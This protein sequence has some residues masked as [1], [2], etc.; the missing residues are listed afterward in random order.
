M[1]TSWEL[2]SQWEVSFSELTS[3]KIENRMKGKEKWSFFCYCSTGKQRSKR[4]LPLLYFSSFFFFLCVLFFLLFFLG[5]NSSF[6][7]LLSLFFFPLAIKNPKKHISQCIHFRYAVI[8]RMG[9]LKLL[10]IVNFSLTF[11]SSESN[12]WNSECSLF[13]LIS[14]K[15]TGRKRKTGERREG[16]KKRS[17]RWKQQ[18]LSNESSVASCM[19]C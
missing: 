9:S 6:P 1:L 2:R 8:W 4:L 10:L 11:L 19:N 18:S 7:S 17:R 16:R 13:L 12:I 14:S 15:P 5:R 3:W